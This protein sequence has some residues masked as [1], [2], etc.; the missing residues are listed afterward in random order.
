MWP[1]EEHTLL[2]NL[3]ILIMPFIVLLILSLLMSLLEKR[4]EQKYSE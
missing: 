2:E 1:Y 4:M 3:A